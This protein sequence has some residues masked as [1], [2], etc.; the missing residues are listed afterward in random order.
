MARP[1]TCT[2]V[3]DLPPDVGWRAERRHMGTATLDWMSV[4]CPRS[5][6]FVAVK[7]APR[8]SERAG[9]RGRSAIEGCDEHTGVKRLLTVGG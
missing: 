7:D 8:I 9:S 3:D 2:L 6:A 4:S 1:G 5:A